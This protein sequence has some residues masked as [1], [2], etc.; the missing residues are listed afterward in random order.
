MSIKQKLALGA[1]VLATLPVLIAIAAGSWITGN[2]AHEL[3]S[4]QTRKQLVAV[5]D[6]KSMQIEGYF[7]R[8]RAQIETFAE[9][10]MIVDAMR[11]F[12]FAYANYVDHAGLEDQDIAG[13]REDLSGYY[14]KQFGRAY[15]EI[16]PHARLDATQL[17]RGSENLISLQHAYIAGNPHPLGEKHRL[18]A[19]DNGTQYDLVHEVYHPVIRSYLEKFDYADILL[20]DSK[21]GEIV[22]SVFKQLDYATSLR[23][24]PYAESGSGEVFAE[25]NAAKTPDAVVIDDFSAYTP[26]FEKPSAFIAAPIFS[27]TEKIGVLV[28]QL[29]IDRI[30]AVMTSNGEWQR[31]GLGESGETYLIGA[32][33][34]MRNMSRFLVQ[35]PE[36]YFTA[37][38]RA[39]ASPQYVSAMRTLRTSI[40]IQRVDT[41]GAGVALAG[42]SGFDVYPDYRGV[43]V[44]AAY[45][46]LDIEGMNWAIVSKIDQSEA[47]ATKQA[48]ISRL[49]ITSGLIAAIMIALASLG[50]WF[51]A[52]RLSRSITALRQVIIEIERDADLAREIVVRDKDE[53]GHMATAL[54]AMFEKFRNTVCSIVVA[55]ESLSTAAI[56]V[57]ET[58]DSTNAG[59]N[60]QRLETD[61]VATAMEQM[62]ATVKEVSASASGAADA[63]KRAKQGAETGHRLVERAMQDI[64]NL[65]EGVERT[66]QAIHE[67]DLH[68]DRI[69]AVLDVI[70]GIA[71]QTNLLALNAAIEA[72]RAG[73]Q[74]RGFAVVADEVRTLASRTQQSTQEIQTIIEQFQTGTRD[75]VSAME[76]S[77]EQARENVEQAAKA[78]QALGD[79]TAA[80]TQITEM[81]DLIASA[82][83]EQSTMTD[84]VSASVVAIAQVAEC[85]TQGAAGT[86]QATRRLNDLASELATLVKQFKV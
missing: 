50:G 68:S 82:A 54:N 4:E 1:F 16:N 21:S 10:R 70:G 57:A 25:A 40:G 83:C 3:M 14:A 22:Y 32:D 73:E 79:I 24:G 67:L 78:A 81:N 71:E 33:Q 46:P 42:N 39:G 12:S 19:G 56:E 30:D 17:L 77:R 52:N 5:R 7:Q 53:T 34:T 2:A 69:G 62:S 20:V 75:A 65:A 76:G 37:L 26:S 27:G 29:P 66:A 41:P 51:A 11:Q 60:K 58:T 84:S 38:Q 47:G 49:H 9:D 31:A 44:L 59:V 61:Q 36:G 28:F 35:D 23:D 8:I 43:P 64:N 13:M 55:S 48:L 18:D 80:V 86:A 72:A 45:A 6:S 74:G 15:N 85:T 63:A